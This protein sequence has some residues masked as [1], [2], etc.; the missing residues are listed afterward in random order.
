LAD[1]LRLREVTA[2]NVATWAIEDGRIPIPQL[3][4]IVGT[5]IR[6]IEST[7]AVPRLLVVFL[8]WCRDDLIW[9]CG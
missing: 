4:A 8:M 2:H 6:E 9:L 5:S 1:R 3:A 7:L